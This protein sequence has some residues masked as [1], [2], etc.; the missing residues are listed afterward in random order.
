M[1]SNTFELNSILFHDPIAVILPESNYSN[2][3]FIF[4]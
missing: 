3:L 1:K 4:A 2:N